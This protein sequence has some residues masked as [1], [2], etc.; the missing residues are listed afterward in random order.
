[1]IDGVLF[2]KLEYM[3]RRIRKQDSIPFGGIQ[4]VITGDFYQL[5]PVFKQEQDIYGNQ[6]ELQE[7]LLAFQAKSWESVVPMT[8]ELKQVFRQKMIVFLEC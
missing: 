1:M 2:D 4:V 7:Q 3:A 8:V 6:L 5:P